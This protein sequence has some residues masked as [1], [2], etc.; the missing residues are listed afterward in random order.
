MVK[1]SGDL[2]MTAG[3]PK[4]PFCAAAWDA[5]SR[6][7][8]T[9]FVMHGWINDDRVMIAC[10]NN[11]TRPVVFR[12]DIHDNEEEKGWLEEHDFSISLEDAY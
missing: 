11:R 12:I 1:G 3:G 9:G 10:C 6:Y 2:D 5:V 7:I 4:M 8:C